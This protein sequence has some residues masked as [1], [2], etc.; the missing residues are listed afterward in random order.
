MHLRSRLFLALVAI[1]AAATSPAIWALAI[2]R[3]PAAPAAVLLPP[4]GPGD[5]E[6]CGAGAGIIDTAA[7]GGPRDANATYLPVG[8]AVGPD[9]T[10]YIADARSHRVCRV[11]PAGT[12][13][14]IAG[15]DEPGYSGDGGP[16][17][18]ASVDYPTGVAFGPDGSLY[19]ADR[20]NHRIRKVDPEGV[21]TTVA[22]SGDYDYY[23]DGGLATSLWAGTGHR[24]QP[25]YRRL[26]EPSSSEG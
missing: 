26:V 16:A 11:R 20:Q 8:V 21:I 9:G 2:A 4:P 12:I 23:G 1:T 18:E 14:S 3:L 7:G 6:D 24:R 25:I 5:P 17:T 19:I 22:G 15:T 13:T 10:L